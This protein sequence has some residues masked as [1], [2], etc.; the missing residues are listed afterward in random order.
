MPKETSTSTNYL[1]QNLIRSGERPLANLISKLNISLYRLQQQREKPSVSCLEAAETAVIETQKNIKKRLALLKSSHQH[2]PEMDFVRI[3][4]NI[5]KV[6]DQ[7]N[8]LLNN[9]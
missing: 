5:G 8:K 7:S 1:T 2:I 3:V 4:R 9:S 6:L